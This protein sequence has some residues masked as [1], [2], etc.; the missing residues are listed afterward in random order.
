M[1]HL[2][3][4]TEICGAKSPLFAQ[5]TLKPALQRN[6]RYLFSFLQGQSIATNKNKKEE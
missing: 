6:I 2:S 3:L 4:G 5:I 1:I